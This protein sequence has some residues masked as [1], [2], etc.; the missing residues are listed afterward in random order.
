[1]IQLFTLVTSTWGSSHLRLREPRDKSAHIRT[2]VADIVELL[3][4]CSPL[5]QLC[6]DVFQ[7]MRL[8]SSTDMM[9]DSKLKLTLCSS[10]SMSSSAGADEP[11]QRT[12]IN[13]WFHWTYSGSRPVRRMRCEFTASVF[14][15]ITE[16]KTEEVFKALESRL[17]KHFF[18]F[19]LKWSPKSVEALLEL[20]FY[21]PLFLC[22][23]SLSLCA[24]TF[25][26]LMF[27]KGWWEK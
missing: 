27:L 13:C 8:F 23:L 10:R 14:F 19:E 16:E 6:T 26:L 2:F 7:P 24:P 18:Y 12:T 11:Q 22:V 3:L 5:F 1:M 17:T 4:S 25:S 20:I 15:S 21:N 9:C